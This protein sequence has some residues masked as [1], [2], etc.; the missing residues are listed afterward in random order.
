[1]ATRR[2]VNRHVENV[3]CSPRNP[4]LKTFVTRLTA[5]SHRAK[6]QQHPVMG[7]VFM[8][9]LC[10]RYCPQLYTRAVHLTT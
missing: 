9:Q 1:M 7:S 5:H 6:R 4:T 2:C 10:S 3:F 8:Y